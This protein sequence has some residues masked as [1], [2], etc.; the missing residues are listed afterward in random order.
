MGIW[1]FG[2]KLFWV[3]GCLESGLVPPSPALGFAC[4]VFFV[5]VAGCLESLLVPPSPALGF[6][7]LRISGFGCSLE[8]PRVLPVRISCLVAGCLEWLLVPPSPALGFCLLRISGFG[9]RL[10]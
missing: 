3:A 6:C 8:S 4:C 7:L 10:S 1:G 5:L 2:Y 9:C